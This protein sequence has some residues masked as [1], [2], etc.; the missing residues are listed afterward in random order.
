MAPVRPHEWEWAPPS[1]LPG[2]LTIRAAWQAIKLLGLQQLDT[3]ER[4]TLT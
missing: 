2:E 1:T 3:S 4:L